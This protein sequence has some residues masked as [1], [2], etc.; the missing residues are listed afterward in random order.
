[1]IRPL[2]GVMAPVVTPFAD[3]DGG[4]DRAAFERNIRAHLDAGLS[5]VLV[6]GSSGEAALLDEGERAALLAWARA[7]V[8][9]DRWLL[10]GIGGESTRGVIQRARVAADA[11]ADA[12]LVVS[13]H[14]FGRRM[15]EPALLA[16]FTAVAD[17][18][19]LPVLLYNIP[20]YAHLVLS[21]ELVATLAM[22]PNVV[23]MKDSAGDLPTLARYAALQSESFKVLT[24]HAGTFAQALALG[25][26]GGILA[27]SLFAPALSRA[28]YE[29]AR[30]GDASTGDAAQAQLIPMA[31]DIVAALGPAGLKAAMDLVGMDGG[32]PRA[33]LLAVDAAERAGVIAALSQAG[34]LD[35]QAGARA[36]ALATSAA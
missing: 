4:L 23:G 19:P 28:V 26:A 25:V 27:V 9:A 29:A 13:P 33:P 15:T 12:V 31:R 10:A 6:A 34:V 21:P 11:G 32:A 16:H 5:G 1:M 24:G 36:P 18:S 17:A 8:P 35:A 3:A 14:Y 2:A 7:L 22:H 20:V 30:G